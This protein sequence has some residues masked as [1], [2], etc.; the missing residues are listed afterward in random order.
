VFIGGIGMITPAQEQEKYRKMW[1]Q[2]P[3]YRSHSPG[4]ELVSV[5]LSKAPWAP[6]DT[7]VDAGCGPGRAGLRLKKA[8]LDVV[9]MDIAEESLDKEVRGKGIFIQGC[10]WEM[11]PHH[12]D[13]VYCC[14]VLE[15][16]PPEHVDAALDFLIGSSRKGTFMQ[17]ALWADGW[18]SKIGETLHLTVEPAEWWIE[19]ITKRADI[20]W[21]D[22]SSDNRLILLAGKQN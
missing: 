5:F 8:G 13:W 9:W 11:E 12:V 17:I 15:H 22:M 16:I 18:G 7:L 10:L 21:R 1:T 4:E 20:L 3:G 6:G 2:V 14:D 19:K